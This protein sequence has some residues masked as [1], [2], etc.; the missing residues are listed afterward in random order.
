VIGGALR[1]L[2][3]QDRAL[4]ARVDAFKAGIERRLASGPATLLDFSGVKR[5]I[6]AEV[7]AERRQHLVPPGQQ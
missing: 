3:E 6:L 2:K 4:D 7:E 1:P 5:R